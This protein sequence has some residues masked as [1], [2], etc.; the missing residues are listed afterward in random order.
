MPDEKGRFRREWSYPVGG[1]VLRVFTRDL[2]RDPPVDSPRAKSW[3][4]D[5]A[6]FKK[7]E[8]AGF[9]PEARVGATC[10]IPRIIVTRIARTS[11]VDNVRGQTWPYDAK[12]IQ[13]AELNATVTAVEGGKLTLKLEGATRCVAKGRWSVSGFH[14]DGRP[15]EQE[16]GV[17]TK[18]L[19]SAVFDPAHGRFTRFDLVAVGSRWGSTQYNGRSRDRGPAPFGASIE[20]AGD[21]PAERVAPAHAYA[22]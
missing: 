6:W 14:D 11:L 18:V 13:M 4:Q 17:E 5:Y 20:L 10:T 12:D 19:G 3:N 1:M 21:T 16:R 8:V 15:S 7:E 9:A 2:P 22:E